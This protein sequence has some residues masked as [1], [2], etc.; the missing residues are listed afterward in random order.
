MTLDLTDYG[1]VGAFVVAARVG[2]FVLTKRATSQSIANANKRM[3]VL[4]DYSQWSHGAIR[5]I[6]L[7]L[8][9]PYPPAPSIHMPTPPPVGVTFA[10]TMEEISKTGLEDKE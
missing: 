7:K 6:L 8:Q 5:A 4:R 2:G 3:D 1:I 10:N 9:I